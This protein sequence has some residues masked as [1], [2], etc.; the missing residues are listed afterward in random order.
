MLESVG[1]YISTV[2]I[3]EGFGRYIARQKF[4]S[5]HYYALEQVYSKATGVFS[6]EE[7]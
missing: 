6:Y 7:Y 4:S 1:D 3:S 2:V 5:L